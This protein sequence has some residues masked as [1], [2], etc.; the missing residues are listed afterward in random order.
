MISFISLAGIILGLCLLI[1]LA[2]NGRSIIWVAPVCAVIVALTSGLNVLDAYLVDYI[3]G[4][5]EYV[6]SWFPAFF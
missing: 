2:Y 3:R 5:G 6:I 4:M 1:Y